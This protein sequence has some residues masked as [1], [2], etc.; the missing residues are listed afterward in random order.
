MPGECSGLEEHIATPDRCGIHY[1][2]LCTK[3]IDLERSVEP[4][5]P[6]YVV[7]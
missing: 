4:A 3:G 7:H 2:F 6:R 5:V 1:D